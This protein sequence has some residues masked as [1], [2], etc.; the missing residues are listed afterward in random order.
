MTLKLLHAYNR[1]GL[2][3]DISTPCRNKWNSNKLQKWR[4]LVWFFFLF[5]QLN[6]IS[7][8]SDLQEH[9]HNSRKQYEVTHMTK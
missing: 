3:E 9:F 8:L 6:F 2:F 4:F 1:L 7:P 5:D